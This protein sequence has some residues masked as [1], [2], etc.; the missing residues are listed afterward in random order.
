MTLR[1]ANGKGQLFSG[2]VAIAT[3]VFLTALALALYLWD[4]TGDDI[5]N[6]ENLRDMERLGS[7]AIEQLVRTPGL[8]SDW[9]YA[10]V[11][12]PGL[13]DEDRVINMTKAAYFVEL[14]NETN[15][16]EY[17]Y[18]MGIGP[19]Q[20]YMNVT[21]LDGEPIIVSN[22]AF[23]DELNETVVIVNEF[24]TGLVPEDAYESLALLRTAIYNS[25]VVRVNFIVWR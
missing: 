11:E 13:A 7:E 21:D 14:M 17:G 20:F 3:M 2:D 10:T 5:N 18:L 15:Y 16:P 22:E 12:I 9:N 25:T 23:L 8:P 24:V 1:V 6:A 19:Y 4:S